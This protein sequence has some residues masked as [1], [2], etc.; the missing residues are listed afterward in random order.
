M[1]NL[2][3]RAVA[4]AVLLLSA[5]PITGPFA[6]DAAGKGNSARPE[7]GKPVQAAID[8]LRS[9]KSR[10]AM[11]RL[12]EAQAVRDRTPYEN[13]LIER[14]LGQVAIMSGDPATAARALEAAAASPAGPE[15]EK[16]QLLAAPHGQIHQHDFAY[17]LPESIEARSLTAHRACDTV[18]PCP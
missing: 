9:K 2:K 18:E 6:Q 7:V 13:Y 4:A 10:E 5:L 14:V 17:T 8:L 3:T 11:A 15:G 1:R 16:R 12:R